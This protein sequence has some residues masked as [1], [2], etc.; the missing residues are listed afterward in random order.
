MKRRIFNLIGYCGVSLL[1]AGT[2]FGQAPPGPLP[3]PAVAVSGADRP[4][5][6]PPPPKPRTSIIGAWKLNH[7]DSD[8]PG[9]K[10]RQAKN[11][12]KANNGNS[13]PHVGVGIPGVGMGGGGN[14]RQHPTNAESDADREHMQELL[15]PGRELT[16]AQKDPKDPEID[17][18]DERDRKLT[19]FTD[20]RKLEKSKTESYQQVA[21]HWDDSRLVTDEKTEHGA[22]MSRT[23][24]LS[25]DGL[26]LWETVKLTTGKK[27][28]PVT[29]RYVYD[30]LN[31]RT[32]AE[33][34]PDA[35]VLKKRTTTG[36]ATEQ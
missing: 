34:D 5:K 7:D 36:S 33:A 17:V 10:M 21:A 12:G 32:A 3:P 9:Q 15:S 35:P 24:E 23:F 26:Q 22:K 31:E 13:G 18:S 28:Y 30:Q 29:I 2:I 1:A 8:D 27:D 14:G 20:G 25:S 16:L 19:L 11:S 6:A 4:V